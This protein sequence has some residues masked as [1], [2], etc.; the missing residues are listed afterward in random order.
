VAD[1]PIVCT[2]QPGEL[3]AR[4]MALLPGVAKRARARIVIDGGYRLDFVASSELLRAIVD[5]I[6]AERQCCRFLRFRLTVEADG[7]S[8][9]LDVTGPSGTK[10]FLA[11]LFEQ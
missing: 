10:E 2:L 11:D 5:M 9:I 6:D 7:E 1:L 3:N 8:L 4:A